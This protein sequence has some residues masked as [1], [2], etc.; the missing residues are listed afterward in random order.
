[1]KIVRRRFFSA[2]Q[3]TRVLLVVFVLVIAITAGFLYFKKQNAPQNELKKIALAPSERDKEIAKLNED[4]DNDGLKEWEE[5]IFHTD[6]NNADTDED[7][8]PDG[9]EIKLGRNPLAPAPNDA[10]IPPAQEEDIKK[11]LIRQPA[12]LTADFAAR[13]LKDPVRQIIA[14]ETPILDEVGAGNYA[15]KLL[16]RSV[17][18]SAPEIKKGDI[19]LTQNNKD[20]AI[21]YFQKM[22]N[23]FNQ[24]GARGDNEV[25]I[26]SEAFETQEYEKLEKLEEYSYIYAK[27]ISD[28]EMLPVPSLFADFH[29]EALNYISKFKLAVEIMRNAEQDPIQ[30]IFA[31]VERAKLQDEFNVFLAKSQKEM[32]SGF[33]TR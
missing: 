15:E 24:L 10:L 6:S 23:I 30:A 27:T 8:T 32:I 2:T 5:N 17:L 26:A 18:A 20:A 21:T 16:A 25:V 14:G 9:E 28:L 22:I 7:G 12:N 29:I 11:S 33:A 1:M 3:K 4:A 13:F 31:I 19:K